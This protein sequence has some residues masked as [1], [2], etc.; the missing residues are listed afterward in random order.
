ML[1]GCGQEHGS[2]PASLL[3]G[4]RAQI[5][6]P[7][8]MLRGGPE[9][10]CSTPKQHCRGAAECASVP[11]QLWRGGALCA[12]TQEQLGRGRAL[13]ATTPQEPS[14]EESSVF[15]RKTHFCWTGGVCLHDGGI[16]AQTPPEALVEHL[17]WTC[18]AL[19]GA[20]RTS[21]Q[22]RV[23]VTSLPPNHR[24]PPPFRPPTRTSKTF[25]ARR[26]RAVHSAFRTLHLA[27]FVIIAWGLHSRLSRKTM[28]LRRTTKI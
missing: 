19:L 17:L 11:Q 15:L 21:R 7:A 14:W 10:C 20:C 28:P 23:P 8:L 1:L 9:L 4:G 18:S 22:L 25:W 16:P 2:S 3:G 13:C 26:H 12:S 24:A 5:F 6:C 27:N